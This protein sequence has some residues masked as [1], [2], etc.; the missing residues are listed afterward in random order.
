MLTCH[1]APGV[2]CALSAALFGMTYS[3]GIVVNPTPESQRLCG[4]SSK[5]EQGVEPKIT[6]AG[7][8]VRSEPSVKQ[9]NVRMSERGRSTRL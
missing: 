2:P 7:E 5:L 4:A 9:T 1:V 6:F 8:N 3:L